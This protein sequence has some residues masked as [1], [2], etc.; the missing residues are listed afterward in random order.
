MNE[1]CPKQYWKKLL[2]DWGN[3][4]KIARAQF[5]W[6][7]PKLLRNICSK[8][9]QYDYRIILKKQEKSDNKRTWP[10]TKIKFPMKLDA[11][12]SDIQV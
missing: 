11:I 6:Y 4:S 9:F 10:V 2:Q 1:I 7:F 12:I 8:K 5:L 3:G